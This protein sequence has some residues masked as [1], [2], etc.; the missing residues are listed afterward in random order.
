MNPWDR[1]CVENKG[2]EA[3]P[4]RKANAMKCSL[5]Q[6]MISLELDDRL[7]AR[8][9]VRLRHHVQSCPACS[10]FAC[11]MRR[12][13]AAA[14]ELTEKADADAFLLGVHRRMGAAGMGGVARRSYRARPMRGWS[15][16]GAMAVAGCCLVL[17]GV[18]VVRNRRVEHARRAAVEHA[19][20]MA[21]SDDLTVAVGGPLDDIAAASLAALGTESLRSGE[22]GE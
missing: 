21:V 1:I 2:R 6:K 10:A 5:A 3:P 12:L 15:L 7:S 18:L 17:A 9:V 16:S 11:D 14:S 22:Q 20:S 8:D 19:F 4:A 13:V